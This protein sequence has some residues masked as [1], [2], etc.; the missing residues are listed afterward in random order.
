MQLGLAC[1]EEA[2]AADHG[3]RQPLEGANGVLLKAAVN[4]DVRGSA[5]HRKGMRQ[6]I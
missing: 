1:V 3:L 6:P 2:D 4:V 5:V